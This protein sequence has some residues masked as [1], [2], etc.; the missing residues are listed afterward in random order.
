MENYPIMKRL[1]ALGALSLAI[2]GCTQSS[3]AIMR[4]ASS[5][6]SPLALAPA[7]S[8]RDTIIQGAATAP[9]ADPAA[10]APVVAQLSR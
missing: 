7:R 5:P 10:S 4:G 8:N 9:S 1:L 6:P 2:A 3:G